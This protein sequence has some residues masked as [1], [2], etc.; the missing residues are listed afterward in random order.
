[1]KYAVIEAHQG[2]FSVSVMCRVLRVSRSGYYDWAKREPSE[3]TPEEQRLR[4]EIRSIH[5]RSG[6]T[7]G[8]P[9]VHRHLRAQESAAVASG[10][11]A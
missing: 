4:I 10:S 11:R 3:P 2:E 1:M 8:S 6:C 5:R 9:R 7:Y